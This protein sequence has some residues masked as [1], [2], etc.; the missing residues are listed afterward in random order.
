MNF[1]RKLLKE[2]AEEM[3][4]ADDGKDA[5]K[6]IEDLREEVTALGNAFLSMSKAIHT[7]M[8]ILVRHEQMLQQV[9]TLLNEG[10]KRSSMA[11]DMPDANRSKEGS[12]KPN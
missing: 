10:G 1:I 3:A 5:V 2:A 4:K 9:L 7:H 6:T 11:L 8:T 12:D